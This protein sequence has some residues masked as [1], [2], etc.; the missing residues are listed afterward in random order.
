MERV[1][2]TVE[3]YGNMSATAVPVALVEALSEDRLE[4]NN[5]IDARI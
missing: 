5:W 2:L 3:E 1:M 4:T